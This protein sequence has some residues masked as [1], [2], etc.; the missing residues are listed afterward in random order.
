MF[1]MKTNILTP[2]R[3]QAGLKYWLSFQHCGGKIILFHLRTNLSHHRFLTLMPVLHLRVGMRLLQQDQSFQNNSSCLQPVKKKKEKKKAQHQFVETLLGP[4]SAGWGRRH[5]P[6]KE[7]QSH[8]ACVF[9]GGGAVADERQLLLHLSFRFCFW[10]HADVV[11][12][13]EALRQYSDL[14]LVIC[15]VVWIHCQSPIIPPPT[16]ATV[17]IAVNTCL[18]VATH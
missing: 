9:S 12:F 6:R 14:C 4:V 17:T 18:F 2:H 13:G 11:A 8:A 1:G 7:M 15:H 10:E 5:Y 16:V 3:K